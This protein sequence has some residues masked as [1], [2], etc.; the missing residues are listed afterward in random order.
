[1]PGAPEPAYHIPAPITPQ[2]AE[3]I[4]NLR[5]I[6]D[7]IERGYGGFNCFVGYDFMNITDDI[8]EGQR[9]RQKP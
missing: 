4:K 7:D 1:M 9:R 6:A 2:R 5:M 3:A 8:M